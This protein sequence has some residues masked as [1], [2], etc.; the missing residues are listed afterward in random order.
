MKAT[1]R[2]LSLSDYEIRIMIRGMNEFRNMLIAQGIDTTDVNR[3]LL[4]IIDAPTKK[5][6]FYRSKV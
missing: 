4:K 3:I 6:C 1:K 5:S 2:Y